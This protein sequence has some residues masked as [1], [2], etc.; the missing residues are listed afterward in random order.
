MI[1]AE[2]IL[3]IKKYHFNSASGKDSTQT[4][5]IIMI[6]AENMHKFLIIF[7]SEYIGV[8]QRQICF[9]IGIRECESDIY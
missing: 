6:N 5:M 1:N 2:F 4:N 8:N 7:K 3:M 9:S